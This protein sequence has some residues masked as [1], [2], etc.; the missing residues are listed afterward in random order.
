MYDKGHY[1]IFIGN[2]DASSPR[3]FCP[4]CGS[5]E[6]ID[7]PPSDA[8]ASWRYPQGFND[9]AAR[10]GAGWIEVADVCVAV[11]NALS[12]VLASSMRWY[13]EDVLSPPL[14]SGIDA[15]PQIAIAATNMRAVRRVMEVLRL[16]KAS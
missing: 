4:L 16:T 13:A 8:L 7:N 12:V 9:T 3:K 6:S 15:K 11:R 14:P 10:V 1:H 5:Q 2:F